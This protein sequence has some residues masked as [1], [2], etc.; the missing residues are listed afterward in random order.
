MRAWALPG[1]CLAKQVHLLVH[2]CAV[3]LD[4]MSHRNW[5]ETKQQLSRARSGHLISC[6]LVSLHFLCDIL[7][8][9]PVLYI[10]T[11]FEPKVHLMPFHPFP[12]RPP[13][14]RSMRSHI[15]IAPLQRPLHC[16]GSGSG[17]S[18][19][20]VLKGLFCVQF[21]ALALKRSLQSR[22]AF[23]RGSGRSELLRPLRGCD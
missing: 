4:G 1:C 17:P 11:G 10:Y 5:R 19:P 16:S 23:K 3:W 18:P 14:T 6:C 8:S 12:P 15:N 9:R 20:Y 21:S 13:S 7:S 22:A 2:L